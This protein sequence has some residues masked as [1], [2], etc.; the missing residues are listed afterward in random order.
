MLLAPG[1]CLKY[2]FGHCHSFSSFQ[3]FSDMYVTDGLDRNSSVPSSVLRLKV[4]KG[5]GL[6]FGILVVFNRVLP[7]Q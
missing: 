5:Q 3:L 7:V 1:S 2:L 6:Q 4:D